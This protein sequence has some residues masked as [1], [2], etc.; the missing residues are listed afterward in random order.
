MKFIKLFE[1]FT[2]QKE[3]EK[4]CEI[5]F[6]IIAEKTVS[7]IDSTDPDSPHYKIT[8]LSRIRLSEID[9]SQYSFSEIKSFIKDNRYLKI[10]IIDPV[11]VEGDDFKLVAN[12]VFISSNNI[13]LIKE[14]P[15]V[16]DDINNYN[17]TLYKNRTS[18]VKQITSREYKSILLH[19]LIHAYDHY[20]S[21]GKALLN[22]NYDNKLVNKYTDTSIEKTKEEIEILQDNF[23]K[24]LNMRYEVDARF[25]EAIMSTD[26]YT[27]DLDKTMEQRK[28]V[29]FIKDF[30]DAF[31]MFTNKFYAYRALDEDQK[32]RVQSK[33]G[34]FYLLEKDLVDDM[35]SKSDSF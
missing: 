34:K 8:E 4:L 23:K 18:A 12:G 9:I 29:Y 27:L 2:S 1:T 6:E 30:K 13:I 15:N 17:T 11:L 19:E 16:L 26:F 32:K 31:N 5:C 21:S 14:K 24:Y 33:F 10:M 22:P 25:A 28:K 7:N 20:R 35:N 3:L